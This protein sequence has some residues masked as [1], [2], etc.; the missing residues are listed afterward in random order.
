MSNRGTRTEVK[1]LDRP[2]GVEMYGP[3]GNRGVLSDMSAIVMVMRRLNKMR[4]DVDMDM[5][6][7]S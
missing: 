3:P 7:L 2:L 5:D 6:R 1:I 4:G